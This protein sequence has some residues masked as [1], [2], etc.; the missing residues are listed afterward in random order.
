[1]TTPSI[2]LRQVNGEDVDR[3]ESML[4]A[5]GLPHQDVR[6]KPECFFL[7]FASAEGS[8]DAEDSADAE[9]STDAE[10]VGIG[11]IETCGSNGLLRSVVVTEPNR[12]QGYGTALCEAMED[13]A[14]TDG[15]ETLYL[16]TTTAAAFFRRRGYEPV[17]RE[18]APPRIRV[19]TE[20]AD[21]CPSSATCL[22]KA[23]R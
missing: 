9:G 11:G 8:A 3:V 19:T 18:E 5:N 17:D 10:L 6:A 15:V 1:M 23:L 21:L 7:A 12:G 2:T 22:A 16:L 13:R 4:E 14:R 20:F